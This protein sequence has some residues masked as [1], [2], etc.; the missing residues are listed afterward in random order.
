MGRKGAKDEDKVSKGPSG[1]SVE[2]SE[3]RKARGHWTRVV[4][5][6]ELADGAVMCFGDGHGFVLCF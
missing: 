3:Y 6:V 2:H 5:V 1:F 4:V